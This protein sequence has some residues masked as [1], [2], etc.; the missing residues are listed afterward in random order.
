MNTSVLPSPFRSPTK[1]GPSDPHAPF[2]SCMLNPVH[3]DRFTVQVLVESR[4]MNTSVLPSPFRSPTCIGPSEP[5]I[6]FH[7]CCVQPL[8]AATLPVFA[9]RS[10]PVRAII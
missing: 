7:S 1:I 4:H 8:W 10:K 6:P 3:V 9:T 2:H 5:H